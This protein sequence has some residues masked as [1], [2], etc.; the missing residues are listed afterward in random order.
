MLTRYIRVHRLSFVV[1]PAKKSEV[2][3]IA[4]AAAAVAAE[5]TDGSSGV[6]VLTRSKSDNHCLVLF[7]QG[8]NIPVKIHKNKSVFKIVLRKWEGNE[9][10]T[11]RKNGNSKLQPLVASIKTV[12]TKNK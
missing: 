2:E 10:E 7:Q 3:D 5:G 6:L 4:G 8:S 9:K 11:T 1:H 12:L